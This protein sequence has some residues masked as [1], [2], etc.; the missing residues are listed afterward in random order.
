M[1]KSPA[2]TAVKYRHAGVF[3]DTHNHI[4]GMIR[5][6]GGGS[7]WQSSA[8]VAIRKMDELG[9]K[10]IFVMPPPFSPANPHIF[11]LNELWL[12][13]RL[14][15]DRFECLGGGGTLNYM[16]HENANGQNI[17]G[18]LKHRF[19][20]KA[21]A[22]LNKGAVGFGEFAA[23]HFSLNHHHPF[24]SVS[25]DHPLFLL[26]A[27]IAARRQ[28]PIDI[29]MEAVPEDMVLPNRRI[30]N[31]SGRNPR[32]LTANIPA[33][34]RLLAHNR[35]ARIIWAHAGW[36]NTGRRTAALCRRLMMDH[37]NLYMSIKLS[38]E[39]VPEV[40]ILQGSGKAI[41]PEWLA[42][43]RDFQDRFVM[44]TDQFY[45]VPGQR[46]IGP[47]R[48]ETTRH[49]MDLLPADL[50]RKIGIENPKKIFRLKN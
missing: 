24:E 33:F 37:P 13:K 8:R 10:K 48:T 6:R 26:L 1:G 20:K 15:P 19:E 9:I 17:D 47:Q 39:S 21:A 31:R 16:I 23:L 29:H 4:H 18:A 5:S 49:F 50:V 3:Y 28:V 44:G 42:L 36:C 40:Q 22:I 12:A 45:V 7:D 35:G 27:D 25:P 2:S 34:E 32:R 38:P 14:Y 11:T 43:M 30:L 41:K 46:R